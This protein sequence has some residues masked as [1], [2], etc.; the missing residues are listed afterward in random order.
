M[1]NTDRATGNAVYATFGG[2]VISADYTSFTTSEEGELVDLTAGPD[3][4]H[5]YASLD[6]TDATIDYEGFYDSAASGSAVW[7]KLA[8]NTAGTLIIAPLGTATGKP[9]RTWSRVLVQNR[10]MEMPFED[11]ITISASF[12]A[13]SA[14]AESTY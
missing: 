6:R 2:T 11:G 13:S 14:V 5:Y 4:F 9:K 7:N 3:T 1:P 8:P 12:Q 10:D